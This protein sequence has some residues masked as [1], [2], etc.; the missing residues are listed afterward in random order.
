M[1]RWCVRIPGI[2]G[3][4]VLALLLPGPA[5]LA[6]PAELRVAGSAWVGD[7]PTRIAAS[8]GLFNTRPGADAPAIV[9][10]KLDSG[11]AALDALLQ[12]RADFALAATTPTAIALLEAERSDEGPLVLASV[13]LSSRTHYVLARSAAGITRP[14]DLAGHRVAVMPGTSSDFG[15]SA[16]SVFHDLEGRTERVEMDVADMYGA[17]LREE[18]AAAVVWSPFGLERSGRD[19]G[20]FIRIPMNAMHTIDWLLLT[21]RDVARDHPE[22]VRRVLAGYLAAIDRIHRSPEQAIDDHAD[23]LGLSPAALRAST[24][25]MI[26]RVSMDWSVLANLGT[27]FQWLQRQPAFAPGPALNPDRFLHGQPLAELAPDRVSLP[28]YLMMV[29]AEN[30]AP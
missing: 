26:W 8:E 13:A 28:D 2:V 7:L 16:F 10:D 14:A 3:V 17:L 21:R 4:M 27:R 12:G 11:R 5:G 24:D 29:E 23:Q 1:N 22:V 19:R 6:E 9:V 30:A 20:A 15:W 18:V 25:G